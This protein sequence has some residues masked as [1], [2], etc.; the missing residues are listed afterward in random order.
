MTGLD[1]LQSVQFV[2][3]NEKRLAVMD[4]EDWEVLVE[5]LETLEDVQIVQ[6][7]AQILKNAGGNRQCAGWWSG[8]MFGSKLHSVRKSLDYAEP[9][10]CPEGWRSGIF[11]LLQ[12][13]YANRQAVANKTVRDHLAKK[14]VQSGVL[15]EMTVYAR[16]RIFLQRNP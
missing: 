6:Q 12:T 16:K 5:W 3:L 9:E 15:R 1:A 11:Y 14:L 13:A 8:K 2:T 10:R 7:A 4:A